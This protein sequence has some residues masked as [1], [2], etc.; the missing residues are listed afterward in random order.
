MA[1]MLIADPVGT[2]LLT[3]AVATPRA[4]ALVMTGDVEVA[5][6]SI[7]VSRVFVY[8]RV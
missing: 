2:E 6:L 4:V 5:E 8:E 3:V 7:M 1:C